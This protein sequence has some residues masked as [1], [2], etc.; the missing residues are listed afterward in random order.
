MNSPSRIL[1][2]LFFLLLVGLSQT[3]VGQ[4]RA[5]IDQ[6]VEKFLEEKKYQKEACLPPI[7]C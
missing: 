6:K 4:Q 1:L 7:M 3:G 2:Q 5:Q